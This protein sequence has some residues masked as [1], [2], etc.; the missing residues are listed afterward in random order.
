[1]LTA[2]PGL[3][4]AAIFEEI[5]RRHPEIGPVL[6]CGEMGGDKEYALADAVRGFPKPVVAMMVGRHAP[7]EKRMGHAG[8]LVGSARES[9]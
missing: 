4:A 6:H 7:A 3:R 2:T 8:A 1:M 9:R 5:C